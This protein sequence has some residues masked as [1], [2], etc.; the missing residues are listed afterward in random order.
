MPTVS[1]ES[2]HSRIRVIEQFDLLGLLGAALIGLALGMLG[3]GGSVLTVPVLV[4]L[5]QQEPK[6]AIT[7]SLLV[8]G[9]I[10]LIGAALHARR[11]RPDLTILLLFAPTGMLGSW[12]GATASA[13]VSGAVQLQTLAAAMIVA[14][15]LMIRPPSS[16]Q[17]TQSVQPTA[18]RPATYVYLSLLGLATGAMTGFVGVGGGFLIV[19]AL[20]IGA[21]LP[22]HRAVATS[23]VLISLN[24]YTGFWEQWSFHKS[25]VASLDLATLG[26]VTAMGVAGLLVG[27]RVAGALSQT[28][29]RQ[30]FGFL[31]IVLAALLV[32]NSLQQH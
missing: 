6:M 20:V 17:R 12:L 23:L 19:P 24:A 25:S 26:L 1:C 7:G 16:M 18:R 2:N 11:Q 31:L 14:A 8:V 4:F 5:F 28:K 30:I 9:T 13:T 22:M 21:A 32:W 29:L 3:S 27:E 15:A 10:A